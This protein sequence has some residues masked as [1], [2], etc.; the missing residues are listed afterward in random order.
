MKWFES[1]LDT[2]GKLPVLRQWRWTDAQWARFAELLE[3]RFPWSIALKYAALTG[4]CVLA[5]VWV[6]RWRAGLPL[7]RPA[8]DPFVVLAFGAGGL[9]LVSLGHLA[10][11]SEDLHPRAGDEPVCAVAAQG[12]RQG[13][14]VLWF[15]SRGGRVVRVESVDHPALGPTLVLTLRRGATQDGDI[16]IPVLIP[17]PDQETSRQTAVAIMRELKLQPVEGKSSFAAAEPVAQWRHAFAMTFFAAGCAFMAFT[18]WSQYRLRGEGLA[19]QARLVRKYEASGEHSSSHM[20]VYSFTPSSGETVVAKGGVDKDRY[21]ALRPGDPM[22]ARYLPSDP[23]KS[24]P[25]YGDNL[26]EIIGW[27]AGAFVC[28]LLAAMYA[29]NVA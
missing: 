24:R 4:S 18:A 10:R 20:L 28:A 11:T 15:R 12:L 9:L 22:P 2:F 8:E 1:D 16:D 14:R 23:A 17:A 7:L 13:S 5:L 6:G 3:T 21:E 25:W 19:V 26:Y 27:S 29:K